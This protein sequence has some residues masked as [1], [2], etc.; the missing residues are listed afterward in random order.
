MHF[1]L[2]LAKRTQHGSGSIGSIVTALCRLSAWKSDLDTLPDCSRQQKWCLRPRVG[3]SRQW[4]AHVKCAQAGARGGGPASGPRCGGGLGHLQPDS[5]R[6][7]TDA[8]AVQQRP[9]PLPHHPISCPSGAHLP[10]FPDNPCRSDTTSQLIIIGCPAPAHSNAHAFQRVS[11][12]SCLVMVEGRPGCEGMPQ[13]RL[14]LFTRTHLQG[15][16]CSNMVSLVCVSRTFQWAGRWLSTHQAIACIKVELVMAWK[17]L[18]LGCG[19][20]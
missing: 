15:D 18:R 7:L 13:P 9:R 4:V 6:P 2:P 19:A 14:V 8:A 11:T 5:R 12:F 1:Q 10:L 3:C 17:A 16:V 20:V